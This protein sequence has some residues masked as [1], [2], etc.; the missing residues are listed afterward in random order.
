MAIKICLFG[1]EFNLQLNKL[2]EIQSHKQLSTSTLHALKWSNIL[3]HIIHPLIKKQSLV[4]F[5]HL[6]M[7]TKKQC[8]FYGHG[9]ADKIR[10]PTKG[11]AHNLSMGSEFNSS[12]FSLEKSGGYNSI[13][14]TVADNNPKS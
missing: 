14:I 4:S 5:F 7:Y 1:L 2:L 13:V 3:I 11:A 12:T 10:H 9:L 6:S 8:S